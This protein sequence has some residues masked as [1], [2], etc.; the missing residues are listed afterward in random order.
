M[1]ET[2][3]GIRYYSDVF[4]D[5]TVL[6]VTPKVLG[7]VT[8]KVFANSSPGLSFGNP[9]IKSDYWDNP[10]RVRSLCDPHDG[11]NP[12]RESCRFIK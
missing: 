11:A 4:V 8:P 9:G 12:F 1:L 5:Y 6:F 7:F 2:P 10:E 3:H